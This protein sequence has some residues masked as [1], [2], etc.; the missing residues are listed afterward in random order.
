MPPKVYAGAA[1]DSD[2][3]APCPRCAGISHYFR[4]RRLTRT[5]LSVQAT[6]ARGIGQAMTVSSTR[7][8]NIDRAASS[9]SRNGCRELRL[10][11]EQLDHDTYPNIWDG[12]F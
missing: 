5:P 12:G 1:P 8:L 2:K 9:V 4:V 3:P 7:E 6:A 10:I 11:G